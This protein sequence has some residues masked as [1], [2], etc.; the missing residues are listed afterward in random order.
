MV[1][2]FWT[3]GPFWFF[4]GP[5]YTEDPASFSIAAS[6]DSNGP[7]APASAVAVD[8]GEAA[9]R[10]R[11]LHKTCVFCFAYQSRACLLGAVCLRLLSGDTHDPTG[12]HVPGHSSRATTA[13]ASHRP[14]RCD[15]DLWENTAI[16]QFL[17]L[18][19]SLRG[20]WLQYDTRDS[21]TAT[22]AR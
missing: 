17:L 19:L 3:F 18:L 14:K 22:V 6:M 15:G 2:W 5:K 16:A 13:N 12:Y 7:E 20:L 21:R 8:N 11:V 10:M 1:R 9:A 4:F